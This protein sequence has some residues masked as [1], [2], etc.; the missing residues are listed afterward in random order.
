[1]EQQILSVIAEPQMSFLKENLQRLNYQL[2]MLKIEHPPSGKSLKNLIKKPTSPDKIAENY[3][4]VDIR[5]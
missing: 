2:S 4:G 3:K 5:I 1:M